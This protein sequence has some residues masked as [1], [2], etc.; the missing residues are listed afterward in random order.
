MSKQTDFDIVIIGAGLSGIGAACHFA[1]E[2]PNKSIT[3]FEGRERM[4]G[5]WDLFR[6][7]GIR[8]DSDMFTL[9]YNFKPWTHGKP[10]AD[11]G[12]IK[13]YI[14][15][16]ARDNKID[17]KIQYSK[18]VINAAWSS[19]EGLWTLDV[20][21]QQTKKIQK[22]TANFV[23]S[24]TGYYNYSSGYQPE[25]P[26]RENF[27]GQFIHPQ[28]W[29]ENLD[30]AGKKIVVIGSGATAVTVAPAMTDVAAHVTML[31]RSPTYVMTI[32]QHDG[33]LQT[34][35]K[36]LPEKW[37]YSIIRGRN[38]SFTW[39]FYNYCQKFPNSARKLIL[40]L[41]RKQVGPDFDM[42]HFSPSYGPWDERLCAVPDG[43][44]FKAIR[45]KK[46]SVET[47]H[48]E[49]LTE[50]GIKL[51]SGKELEADIII[52][53]TGLNV[54]LF[55]NMSI[56]KDG[57]PF[58]Y[59]EKMVYR[60]LLLEDLPN[61]GLVFGYTNASW[62]LKADLISQWVC[63]VINKMDKS[64]TPIVTAVNTDPSIVHTPFVDM[65][66]GYIQR[67]MGKVPQQGSKLPWKLY[68][69]YLLDT[70]GLRF[71]KLNDGFLQFSKPN[72]VVEKA[73][74]GKSKKAA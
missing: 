7:P 12:D 72:P 71:S 24:C 41:I 8:S 32:P 25:F 59:Q 31:Q 33:M 30:Y 49:T 2:C 50:N 38:V 73:K 17:E 11:G 47:D 5:T 39:M 37:V 56:E 65:Q 26:G 28:F 36:F 51:K 10:I 14:E 60:G 4:G 44:L 22:V 57:Q 67:A 9:G 1:R 68:Q 42:K 45:E 66:S 21:D 43:D 62:T 35:R 54:Q 20:E 74:K 69:N 58:P 64:G 70:V 40:K 16:T 27:K 6:Y 55:G 18:R 34:L 19:A 15:E 52:S 48:I 3:I 13:S 61:F 23:L 63:R 29:P 53:A 46:M